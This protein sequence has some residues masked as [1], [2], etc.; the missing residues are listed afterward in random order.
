MIRAVSIFCLIVFTGCGRPND[1]RQVRGELD[2]DE[3]RHLAYAIAFDRGYLVRAVAG[4]GSNGDCM[5]ERTWVVLADSYETI[6][7]GK[8]IVYRLGSK[9][10]FHQVIRGGPDGWTVQGMA[11]SRPDPVTVT[12]DNYVGT[13]VARVDSE[14]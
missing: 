13:Y 3:S 7:P 5:G 1:L 2:R 14:R 8:L 10:I 12:R 9:E 4:T 6:S 11:N